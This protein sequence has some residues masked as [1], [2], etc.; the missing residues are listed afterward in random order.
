[1]NSLKDPTAKI[2]RRRTQEAVRI[3]SQYELQACEHNESHHHA[4]ARN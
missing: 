1:M 2:P 3:I 4:A